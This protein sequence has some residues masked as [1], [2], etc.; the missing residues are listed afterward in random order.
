MRVVG[1][2][3]IDG[4]PEAVPKTGEAG[5]LPQVGEE[6]FDLPLQA[7]DVPARHIAQTTPQRR[8]ET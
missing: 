7:I 1:D 4:R 2:V 5:N 6:L 8:I 3:A